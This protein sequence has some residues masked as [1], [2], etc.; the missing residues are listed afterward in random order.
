[1]P[2]A[3]LNRAAPAAYKALLLLSNEAATFAASVGLNPRTIELVKIRSSQI[4]GCAYCLRMHVREAITLGETSDRLAVLA[5][6]RDT[7]YFSDEERAA[8]IIAE[9]VTS[10]ADRLGHVEEDTSALCAE[11]KAAIEWVTIT[12]NAFNRLSIVSEFPVAP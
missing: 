9:R 6:W 10:I 3:Y 7:E 12:I 4:N 5:A 8:L 2:Q 1:M 11:Q